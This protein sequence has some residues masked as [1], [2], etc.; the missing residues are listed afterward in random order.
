[1]VFQIS[2]PKLQLIFWQNLDNNANLSRINTRMS[3]LRFS[4]KILAASLSSTL[5]IAIGYAYS[6]DVT[7]LGA[8]G[9]YFSGWLDAL[10]P[11][12]EDNQQITYTDLQ[13]Q[14]SNTDAAI[15]S[16]GGG[17]RRLVNNEG[18]LGGYLFY[19][20]SKSASKA[21]FNVLSPG[22]EYLTTSWQYRLNTYF[23][24]GDKTDQVSEGWADEFG[25]TQYIELTGHDEYN[26]MQYN[27]ETLSYGADTTVSYRFQNDHRWQLDFT[28]YAFNQTESNA[29]LG[30]TSQLNFYS[31][32]HTQVFIG[33]G[34]DNTNHNRV[35]MGV[36]FTF[37]GHNND[38]SLSNLM[39]SPIYRNL[40]LYT[41]SNGTPVDS[42]ATFGAQQLEAN[43]LWYVDNSASGSTEAGTYEN[44][45]TDIDE[46]SGAS[47]D[48]Q[49]RVIN[50]GADY[51]SDDSITL[52]GTQTM[53]GYMNDYIT[54]ASGNSRPTIQSD[55]LILDGENTLSN[56]QL[57]GYGTDAT[58][59]ITISGS[60]TINSVVVGSTNS[61]TSYTIGMDVEDGASAYINNSTINAY[62]NQEDAASIIG[63]TAEGSGTLSI[64]N[65][66][67][68]AEANNGQTGAQ[69]IVVLGNPLAAL[70]TK[71]IE[72]INST[73]T[74]NAVDGSATGMS[75]VHWNGDAT[76]TN[77]TIT[78]NG[79]VNSS[80][81]VSE[82]F[83]SSG[84]LTISDSTLNATANDGGTATGISLSGM[85]A[86]SITVDDS[87][88]NVTS[89]TGS[90]YAVYSAGN[91]TEPSITL[92]GNDITVTADTATAI[93]ASDDD[94]TLSGN[95][96]N[97]NGAQTSD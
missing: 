19:D 87:T 21:Y 29:L 77:S 81:A 10:L 57:L 23:P 75:F 76:I 43:N 61:S 92:T 5:Y 93:E 27:Y 20:R 38:D 7:L 3:T 34:Y 91:I 11:V 84:D 2:T 6:P 85:N 70:S 44:P 59:G 72:L 33:D 86:G 78:S 55:G 42:Y 90:G 73:V 13:L 9:T 58:T 79:G 36:S 74:V 35:F 97:M 31:N 69:G 32:D 63:I 83:G 28:P 30:I 4:L 17:Y 56:L 16:A 65:S 12:Y 37:G 40:D 48:A 62:S 82:T 46:I 14:A 41:T 39:H 47:D 26:R 94:T 54:I 67:V 45:Y 53:T 68:Y 96:Y 66:V 80:E 25:N 52:T 15:F 50:T 1:M 60:A 8:G 24:F 71:T 95:T 49:I 89:E 22:L 64:N 51:T 88:I 18:V